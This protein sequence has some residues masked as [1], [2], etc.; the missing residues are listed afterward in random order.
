MFITFEGGEGAGKS[1]QVRKLAEAF[2]RAGLPVITTREPGGSPGAE[3]IRRLVVEAGGVAWH[4]TTE[5]L[6]FMAA[7]YDHLETLIKPALARGQT[8]LCDRFFDSTLV[9]QGMVKQVGEEW[10]ARLYHL[11]YGNATPEM[12]LLLDLDPALG[13]A[14]AAG[15]GASTETRFESM[16]LEFHTRLRKGF[17]KLAHTNPQ[18]VYVVDAAASEDAIHQN[19]LA[20]VNQRFGIHLT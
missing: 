19:I 12:T 8:V 13:L 10:L 15:R 4:P 1:T 18:R 14:R 3:A 7:R 11:L 5:A 17:L 20:L 16:G 6:L 2:A 9:Y